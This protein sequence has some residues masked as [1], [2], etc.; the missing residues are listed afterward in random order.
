MKSCADHTVENKRNRAD[1][2]TEYN[3]VDGFATTAN[4]QRTNLSD[5][6]EAYYVKPTAIIEAGAIHPW[7]LRASENQK[8]IIVQCD[9]IR[10]ST[11]VTSQSMFDLEATLD[12]PFA[13]HFNS[14]IPGTLIS[15]SS[16]LLWNDPPRDIPL[17]LCIRLNARD[18]LTKYVRH[19]AS[20]NGGV[21]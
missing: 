19:L 7:A 12:R 17:F 16:L 9:Q 18:A 3:T 4:G 5:M 15:K 13:E 11:G 2:G 10:R 20:G 6:D 8:P 21:S 1:K 14:N